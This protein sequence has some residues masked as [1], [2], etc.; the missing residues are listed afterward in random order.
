MTPQ[1]TPQIGG[2]PQTGVRYVR[3][4][5]KKRVRTGQ[6]QTNKSVSRGRLAHTGTT[7][8]AHMESSDLLE[9]VRVLIGSP[10]A[11]TLYSQLLAVQRLPPALP[12]KLTGDAAV[13][14]PMLALYR[15]NREQYDTVM[16]LIDD[17]RELKDRPLLRDPPKPDKFDKNEYQR[18]FMDQSR[19]RQ[20]RAVA[21]ENDSRPTKDRLIGNA[22]LEFMRQQAKRWKVRRDQVVQAARAANGGTLDQGY[23]TALL[24]QFWAGIDAEL[25]EMEENVRRTGRK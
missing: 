8:H 20:R 2:Y 16:M 21:V 15:T 3:C 24:E 14:N 25:T 6:I 5:P 17:K 13:L 22:R 12:I 18:V 10:N 1:R 4:R 19:V 23:Y 7:N 9:A 11:T